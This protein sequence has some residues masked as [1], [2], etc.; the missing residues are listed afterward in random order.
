MQPTWDDGLVTG[1]EEIDAGHQRLAA[2]FDEV[3]RT[4]ASE[5][6]RA[7]FVAALSHL[8]DVFCDH[9][10][11]EDELMRQMDYGQ[12]EAHR[13]RHD[14]YLTRLSQLLFDCQKH[15]GS[16]VDNINELLFLWKDRH[17]ALFDRPLAEAVKKQR[18]SLRAIEEEFERP[19]TFPS[20]PP[21]PPSPG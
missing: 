9:L 12:A 5:R 20:P 15:N 8:V 18:L 13:A 16:V 6:G 4:L 2:V 14:E 1:V 11:V 17:Q 7:P 3:L 19:S 21:L 10:E